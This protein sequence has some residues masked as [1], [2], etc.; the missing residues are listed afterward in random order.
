MEVK[1]NKEIRN[2]TESM[3]FG[4]SLRQ[5]IFSVLACG[6]AM[7]L[8]F[9]LRSRFGTETLSWVCILGAFP[10]AA[11]GFIKYNGMTAEQFVWAWLKSEFLM[12]KKLMFLPDNLYYET[13]KPTIE[14]YEKGLTTV[15][16]K[17]KGRTP[18]PKKSKKKKAKCSK[19]VNNAENS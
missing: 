5:F 6:V 1:I 7:G 2:Y 18:K 14:A 15:R 17:Q 9:L 13:V 16:K 3:F 11:M 4:L 10:F 19:E 8:Y 12:P